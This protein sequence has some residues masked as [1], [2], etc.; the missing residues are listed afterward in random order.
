MLGVSDSAIGGPPLW[1][2]T[3]AEQLIVPLETADDVVR[4]TPDAHLLRRH[5]FSDKR[6][7]SMVYVWARDS[8]ATVVARFFFLSD[9]SVI[10]DPATGS[11]C[12]NLGGWL[13]ATGHALPTNLEVHQGAIVGRPSL[14]KLRIDEARRIFVSGRVVEVGRGSAGVPASAQTL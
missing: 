9:G 5:A 10:E 3:G 14:L 6:G 13:L 2:D 4:V 8:D 12:A 1:V 7:A 11:A